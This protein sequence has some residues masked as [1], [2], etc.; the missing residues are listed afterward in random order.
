MRH[1]LLSTLKPRHIELLAALGRERH[2]GRAAQALHI[3]QPAASKT[4]A[5]LEQ[6]FGLC[7]CLSVRLVV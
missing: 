1:R 3:T 6:V 7:A 5:Q 2:L 4:L